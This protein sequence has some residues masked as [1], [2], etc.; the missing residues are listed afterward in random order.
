M[1]LSILVAL[2]RTRLIGRSGGLPWHLPADLRRFKAITMGKTV[3]MGRV[4]HESIGRPL[5]GRRNI[6]LTHQPDYV[7]PGCEIFPSL[8]LALSRS[9]GEE[10]VMIIGGRAVYIE[11][12]PICTRIYLTEVDAEL[13]GDVYFPVLAAD[14]WHEASVERHVADSEHRFSYCFKVFDRIK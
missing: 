4:T 8:D 6:V 7:S 13:E 14:A 12:I 2:D 9:R 1:R 3:V 5:P 10:E 11:A